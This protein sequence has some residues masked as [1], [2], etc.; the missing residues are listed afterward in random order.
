[1]M[2]LKMN[3]TSIFAS[4]FSE[5]K[6]KQKAKQTF[7]SKESNDLDN[8]NI[9]STIKLKMIR[10]QSLNNIENNDDPTK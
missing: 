6:D 1:M 4:C 8:Q 9:K 5:L 3:L 7:L 2:N 10:Y